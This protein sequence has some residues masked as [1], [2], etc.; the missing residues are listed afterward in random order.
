MDLFQMNFGQMD[1]F[2]E[3][4]L[5]D[6]MYASGVHYPN[7]KNVLIHSSFELKLLTHFR[8]ERPRFGLDSPRLLKAFYTVFIRDNNK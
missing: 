4:L 1:D 8:R 3:Y 2:F 7:P 5:F 6:S